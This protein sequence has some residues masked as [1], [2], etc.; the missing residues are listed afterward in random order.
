MDTPSKF[1]VSARGISMQGKPVV[2]IT[3]PNRSVVRSSVVPAK[4]GNDGEYE[5]TFTPDVVGTYDIDIIWNG[6]H[7]PG[8]F[9][10]L[11][12]VPHFIFF[13]KLL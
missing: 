8:N 12:L 7:I 9:S 1:F 3:G 2:Q 11:K 13:E 5:V 10:C 6:K 4:S